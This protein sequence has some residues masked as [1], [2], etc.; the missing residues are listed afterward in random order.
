M[1][2]KLKKYIFFKC[3]VQ[4]LMHLTKLKKKKK[5]QTFKKVY[6]TLKLKQMDAFNMKIANNRVS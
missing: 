2:T 3:K 6:Q 1:K 4:F 5:D